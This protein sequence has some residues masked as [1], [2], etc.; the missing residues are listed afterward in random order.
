MLKGVKQKVYV[1]VHVCIHFSISSHRQQ[2]HCRLPWQPQNHT[3]LD[4]LVVQLQGFGGVIKCVPVAL[5]LQ[6]REAAVAIVSGHV[7]VD[8]Y[9]A[10]VI[11]DGLLVVL[12]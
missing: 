4:V 11:T 8:S 10:T 7:W 2:W 12:S 5:H 6:V 3:H 9:G 1:C